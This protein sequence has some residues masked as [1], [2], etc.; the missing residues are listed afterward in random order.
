MRKFFLLV[1]VLVVVNTLSAQDTLKTYWSNQQLKSVGLAIDSV[2]E[3]HWQYFHSD[4]TLMM[5]GNF[6][7]G[8]KVGKWKAWYDNGKLAQEYFAD[9]GPFK[10]WYSNG[11]VESEGQFENGVKTV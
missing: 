11:N 9:N 3:G 5:E 6:K 10:S 2:E 8:Q 7:H 4:G 1:A